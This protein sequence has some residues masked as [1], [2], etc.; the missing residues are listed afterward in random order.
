MYITYKVV[1]ITLST[2]TCLNNISLNI[3]KSLLPLGVS[4]MYG[5]LIILDEFTRGPF[6]NSCTDLKITKRLRLLKIEKSN[7]IQKKTIKFLEF[8]I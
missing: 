3:M 5:I 8:I 7:K 1:I 4:N 6:T 2:F